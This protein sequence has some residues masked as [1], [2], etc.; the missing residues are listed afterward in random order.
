MKNTFSNFA[1]SVLEQN[2]FARWVP[3]KVT[4]VRNG[5]RVYTLLNAECGYTAVEAVS[6]RPSAYNWKK[7]A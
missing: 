7:V 4:A 3:C 1:G 5:V 6:K 2:D